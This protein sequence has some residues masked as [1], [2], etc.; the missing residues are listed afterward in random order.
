MRV[1]EKRRTRE[2]RLQEVGNRIR[3]R[4]EQRERRKGEMRFIG[5]MAKKK[6]YGHEDVAV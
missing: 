1:R 2:N 3:L 6:T 5:Q 4:Q